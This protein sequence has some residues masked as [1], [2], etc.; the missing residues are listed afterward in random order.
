MKRF[1]LS[2]IP[3][4]FRLVHLPLPAA[5]SEERDR[6]MSSRFSH[7]SGAAP[8]WSFQIPSVL[9]LCKKGIPYKRYG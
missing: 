9:L 7:K 6:Q 2:L 5:A 3:N 4:G 8:L 1:I